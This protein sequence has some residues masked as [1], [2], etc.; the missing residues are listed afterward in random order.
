MI[1]QGTG[2][3]M[4][5]TTQW[6]NKDAHGDFKKETR[7]SYIKWFFSWPA[8]LVSSCRH[9]IPYH[10]F[11][12]LTKPR[13]LVVASVGHQISLALLMGGLLNRDGFQP[14]WATICFWSS[15]LFVVANRQRI[16]AA[17]PAFNGLGEHIH[18][19]MAMLSCSKRVVPLASEYN[20]R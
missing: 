19:R 20:Y 7:L 1:N 9:L 14:A 8:R 3:L 16:S 2:L 10:W 15:S 13:R 17:M 18:M 6:T 4:K 11:T 12:E 5:W